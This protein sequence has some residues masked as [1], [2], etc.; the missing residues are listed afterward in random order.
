MLVILHSRLRKFK[1]KE[2]NVLSSLLPFCSTQ[3]SESCNITVE[4]ELP[5]TS[6]SKST[7]MFSIPVANALPNVAFSDRTDRLGIHW[8]GKNN[9][10]EFY[11]KAIIYI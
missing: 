6:Q 4:L 3:T 7:E 1:V 5:M 2:R 10:T 8:E 9:D 11:G